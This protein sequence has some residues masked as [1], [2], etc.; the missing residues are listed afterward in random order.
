VLESFAENFLP[1]CSNPSAPGFLSYPYSGNSAAGFVG[2]M[3]ACG[4]QQNL[5]DA[6]YSASATAMDA[7]I[8]T[9]IR[10]L[11]GFAAQRAP[12]SVSQ[13]G[14]IVTNSGTTSNT[15]ALM[16]ARNAAQ[17]LGR[18][19]EQGQML[20]LAPEYITHYGV[21]LAPQWLGFKGGIHLVKQDAFRFDLSSLG[22]AL[23]AHPNVTAVVAFAGDSRT[24]TCENL[25]R[26]ADL[27]KTKSPDTWLHCDAAHGLPLA[28]V[29]ARRDA[30]A[31]IEKFDTITVDGHK[32]FGLPFGCSVLLFRDETGV[33]LLADEIPKQ[34]DY[35]TGLVTP[36][37]SSRQW[38][39]LKMWLHMTARGL[40]GLRKDAEKRFDVAD[41]IAA[42]IDSLNAFEVVFR[43]DLPSVFFAFARKKGIENSHANL[44]LVKHALQ[45]LFDISVVRLGLPSAEYALRAV[46]GHDPSEALAGSLATALE[47][48]GERFNGKQDA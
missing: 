1:G 20:V 24:L 13:I 6:R 36:L 19:D 45:P 14:G 11:L 2:E 28:F 16:A 15:L 9:W 33:N 31:G 10:E 12:E 8:I 38:S 42:A 40:V 17:K 22:A 39:S 4:L 48:Y 3:L 41:E 21:K 18:G 23:E 47:E 25:E 26:V 7:I 34:G 37:M 29:P 44:R 43:G 35:S 30:L 5:V 32:A 27:V 46:I